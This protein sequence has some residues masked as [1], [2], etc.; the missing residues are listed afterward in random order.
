LDAAAQLF[1]L[2]GF[3]G[4][5]VDEI[6]AAVGLSGPALYHHFESKEA[7]LSEMLVAG[8]EALLANGGKT[9]AMD[10]AES[11]R[12]LIEGQINFA[13]NQPELITVHHRDLVHA[14]DAV[15]HRVRRLQAEYVEFWVSALRELGVGDPRQARAAVHA[16]IGLI[17]STPFSMRL[18][19]DEMFVL[20]RKMSLGA[21]DALLVD[22]RA[23][24]SSTL[25][26][27]GP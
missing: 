14:P 5:T 10:A 6:G 13:L 12:W 15:Q 27:T 26:E 3:H 16:V 2:R 11:L 17:N 1:A 22:P 8:S 19:R 25:G 9:E 24:A 7:L 18:K 23:S 4:V 21:F 20:L